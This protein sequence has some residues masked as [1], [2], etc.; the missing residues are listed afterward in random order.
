MEETSHALFSIGPLE[1]T[2]TVTTMWAIILVLTLLSWLATRNMKEVPGKL[3]NVAE[4]AVGSL[5]NYFNGTLGPKLCKKY[6]PIF[7]TFFI[8]IIVS[9]YSGILPGAGHLAAFHVPTASM[10]VT[11]GLGVGAF[12]TTHVIGSKEKGGFVKYLIGLLTSMTIPLFFLAVIE[13]FVRPFSL[14]LRLYG[15]LYGEEQ[16]TENLYKIF[17]I[18]APLVMQVLSLLFCLIQA[19]VFTML[20]SIYVKEAA[21]EEE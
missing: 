19:L 1:V 8:F 7:A 3:Q 4:M 18:A 17:P 9:N 6:F 12:F 11:A 21:E 10:S 14:A 15:N 2:G 5:Q 20:L 16:V 13:Q